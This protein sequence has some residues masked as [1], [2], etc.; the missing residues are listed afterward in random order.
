MG[1]ILKKSVDWSDTDSLLPGEII[2][3]AIVSL[4]I[5][6]VLSKE[7]TSA[8]CKKLESANRCIVSTLRIFKGIQVLL[9][10]KKWVE[11]AIVLFQTLAFLK[12]KQYKYYYA[13]KHWIDKAIE[14]LLTP[15]AFSD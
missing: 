11:K 5:P 10:Q 9:R 8:I 13:K 2:V 4:Q 15:E 7:D 6:E 12:V 3:K 14:L 1:A